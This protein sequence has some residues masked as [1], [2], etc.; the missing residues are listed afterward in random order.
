MVG[1]SDFLKENF[2]GQIQLKDIEFRYPNRSEVQ[3]LKNFN[4]TIEPRLNRLFISI[5]KIFI[6]AFR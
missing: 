6:S 2:R 1:I 3:V 5:S 4:L